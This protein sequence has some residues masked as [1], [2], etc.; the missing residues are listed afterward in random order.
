MDVVH[1]AFFRI[2]Q[3]MLQALVSEQEKLVKNAI[4]QFIGI[5][6]K[7]EFPDNTW[8]EVLQFIHTLCSSDHIFDREVLFCFESVETPVYFWS[9]ILQ[10]SKMASSILSVVIFHEGIFSVGDVYSFY[11]D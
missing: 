2:K 4:A 3:G 6:G 7:H 11:N 8:P 1:F 5:I 9:K 10:E